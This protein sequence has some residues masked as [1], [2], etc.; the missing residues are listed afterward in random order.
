MITKQYRKSV[1][2]LAKTIHPLADRASRPTH[3]I[4]IRVAIVALCESARSRV[5]RMAAVDRAL[6]L[7]TTV[8]NMMEASDTDSELCA[9]VD[10]VAD[11]LV[12]L[13]QT[14]AGNR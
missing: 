13:W 4:L 3:A 12:T 7:L 6:F 14:L 9:D 2:S 10:A 8:A 1:E 5:D 11:K